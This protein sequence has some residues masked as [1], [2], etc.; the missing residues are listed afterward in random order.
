M[1]MLLELSDAL[2]ISEEKSFCDAEI[3]SSIIKDPE[4]MRSIFLS[5]TNRW[6]EIEEMAKLEWFWRFYAFDLA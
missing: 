3:E 4:F 5:P 2:H 1:M 6:N